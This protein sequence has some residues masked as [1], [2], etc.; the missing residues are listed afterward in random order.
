MKGLLIKEF[1]N[2]KTSFFIILIYVIVIFC[3]TIP[4]S[5]AG[6]DVTTNPDPITPIE[7]GLMVFGSVAPGLFIAAFYP[8]TVLNSSY[9]LDE[10]SNWTPFIISVGVRKS[11]IISS[12]VALSLILDVIF[13]GVFLIASFV[14]GS[15]PLTLSSIIFYIGVSLGCALFSQAL[16]I[17]ICSLWGSNKA[18]VLSIF[19]SFLTT[20]LPLVFALI[21]FFIESLF[22]Y[23]WVFGLVDLFVFGILLSIIVLVITNHFYKKRDF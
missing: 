2:L 10:K 18:I 4:S 6:G 23:L 7:E 8:N 5:I 16:T 1:M 15:I 20:A 21:P 17:M 14:L 11:T 22:N 3:L 9:Q 13:I 12:K 19:L